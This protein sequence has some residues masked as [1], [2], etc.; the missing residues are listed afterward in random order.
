MSGAAL[1]WCPFGDLESARQC[2]RKLVEERLVACAN[3]VP[4]VTSVFRWQGDVLQ[5]SE[6]GV[7][8]KTTSKL[9]DAAVER[10]VALHPYDTPA[11]AGWH[12][13]KAPPE[14]LAWLKQQTF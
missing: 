6:V 2:A 1:I 11:I 10:L 3:I 5:E 14:T 9:L 8:F 13:D 7:L 4:A 12:A